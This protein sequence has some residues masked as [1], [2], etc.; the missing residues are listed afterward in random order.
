MSYTTQNE[1]SVREAVRAMIAHMAMDKIIGQP[2]NTTVNQL[3]QQVAKIAAAVKTSKWGGRHGHLALVLNEADYRTVTSVATADID[4]LNAPPI[5]PTG[6]ANNTTV[7]NKARIM[8]THNLE[9]QEYWKQEAVDAIIVERIVSEVVD[10][11]YVEELEDDYIGYTSQTIKTI[12]QHLKTEW[13][14]VTTL[15]KKIAMAAFNLH[16]DFTTHIT[17]FAR[18]LDKQQKL[19]REINVPAAD[20]TKIQHYVENMYA[21]E[22]F[23]DKEMRAWENKP[24]ANK[25]W[26]NAKLHFVELYKSKRKYSEER[27]ARKGGFESANSLSGKTVSTFATHMSSNPP[28]SIMTGRMTQPDQATMV[29]YTNSLEGALEAAKE[30]AA[31]L[32]TNQDTLLQRINDQQQAMMKQTNEFMKLILAANNNTTGGAA[33]TT[34]PTTGSNSRRD[35]KPAPPARYCKHCKHKEARHFDDDCFELDQNKHRRP[36]YWKSKLNK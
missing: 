16:W 9:N 32:Q 25:T 36:S 34:T 27:E 33:P 1:A 30:H 28:S 23:D 35:W 5:V 8:A 7:T 6:L 4:R 2:T 24:E 3:K 21:S 15:E 20:A 11:T 13:C 29:E 22:M 10:A 19:C 31:S 14:T 17:K 26:D 18:E 12:I